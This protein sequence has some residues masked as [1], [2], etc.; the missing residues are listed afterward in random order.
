MTSEFSIQSGGFEVI[1]CLQVIS[2]I[3]NCISLRYI[4]KK[5][6]VSKHVTKVLVNGI[7]PGIVLTLMSGISI[8]VIYFYDIKSTVTCGLAFDTMPVNF[9]INL[10]SGMV[11]SITRGVRAKPGIVIF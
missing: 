1:I 6:K 7:I 5:L 4:L 10:I 9:T 11:L 2:I 8:A 3:G